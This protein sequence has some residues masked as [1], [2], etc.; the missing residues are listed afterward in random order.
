VDTAYDGRRVVGMDLHR[1]LTCRDVL[2]RDS[3]GA[4]L[5]RPGGHR[6]SG[7]TVPAGAGGPLLIVTMQD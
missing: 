3:L 2:P 7:L 6:S 5:A 1:R 4:Y